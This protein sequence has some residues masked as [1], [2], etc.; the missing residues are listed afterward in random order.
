MKAVLAAAAASLAGL[1]PVT[2]SA[3]AVPQTAGHS[4][5]CDLRIAVPTGDWIID[6]YDPF[7]SDPPI[8]TYD[9][10]F[11]NNGGSECRF[12]PVFDTD[13]A[14]FGLAGRSGR[15]RV[16]YS[17]VDVYGNYDATPIGGRT[18]R[19][20]TH[21]PVVVSPHA[22]QLVRYVLTVAD[23]AIPG[24]GRFT[25]RLL[26]EADDIHG[27]P[28]ADRQILL[29]VNVL[30]SAVMGLAG[31]FRN[32]HGQ[33]DVDLGELS[34]GSPSIPLNLQIHS[35][36]PYKLQITSLNSGTLRLA[37]TQWSVP[38]RLTIGN[39]AMPFGS[40]VLFGNDSPRGIRSDSLPLAFHIGDV[41]DR[42][43]G[44]YVD[45]LTVTVSAD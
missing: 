3:Q 22:Q 12:Y 37:N 26:V 19:N 23:T 41:S 33:A 7:G 16:P 30:P 28:L 35:T 10:T 43:A 13:G 15:G 5:G 34:E 1:M 44:V 36:R 38:Y 11:V 40:S 31:A 4:P 42:R 20:V 29:G 27:A 25:Q 39:R 6:G 8:G 14:A 18:V 45:T 2:A 21:R 17:L 32:N 9:L 24:D